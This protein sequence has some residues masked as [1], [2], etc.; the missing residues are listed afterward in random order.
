MIRPRPGRTFT[1]RV[2]GLIAMT[3]ALY[4]LLTTLVYGLVSRSTFAA[5]KA[6]ELDPKLGRIV[7][8]IESTLPEDDD[9]AK[10]A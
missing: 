5:L 7:E 1:R 9:S 10:A 8:L 3:I 2:L 4:A 6:S